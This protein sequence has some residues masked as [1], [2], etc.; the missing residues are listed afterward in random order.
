M[1]VTPHSLD[2]DRGVH[3]LLTWGR[4]C[5]RLLFFSDKER[6]AFPVPVIHL[7][8]T[9]TTWGEKYTSLIANVFDYVYKN[10]LDEADWFLKVCIRNL[11][12]IIVIF[13]S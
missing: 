9:G 6:N 7:N 3:L 1:V 2:T 4:R 12:I 11:D 5:N 13:V 8:S 10:H